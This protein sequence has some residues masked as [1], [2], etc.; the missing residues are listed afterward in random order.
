MHQNLKKSICWFLFLLSSSALAILSNAS[1]SPANETPLP[2]G[3]QVVL[4]KAAAHMAEKDYAEA[5]R[6]LNAFSARSIKSFDPKASDPRGYHH[7]EIYFALGNC[8]LLQN[9]FI[10][11]T[12]AYQKALA[13]D[14][15]HV[16]AWLNLAKVRYEQK[17][18]LEAAHCFEKGYVVAAEKNPEHLYYAACAYLMAEKYTRSID[19]FE[20]LGHSHP[21]AGKPAWKENH[22]HALLAAERPFDALPLIKLLAQT[23]T[24]KKKIQWQEIL[25]S[26]YLALDQTEK[27]LSFVTRLTRETP[28][29][30]KW[31]KAKAHVQLNLE[32]NEDALCALMIYGYL[33]PLNREEKKLLADLNLQMNIP[34]KAA[35]LYA[36]LTADKS[37]KTLVKHLAMAYRQQGQTAKALAQLEKFNQDASDPILLMLQGDLLYAMGKFNRAASAYRQA[38]EMEKSKGRAWLM[39]GYASWQA[40]DLDQ[41]RRAFL[42]AANDPSQEA[43]AREAL[44]QIR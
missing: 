1:T 6:T 39:A 43:A 24:G 18:P 12:T 13:R 8:Y 42:L 44:Q 3:V 31:W 15:A 4:Q 25:L 11:A 32:K 5:E 10:R 19:L 2:P 21:E 20:Q 28:T 16:G 26:Q 30:A 9:H 14:P 17:A 38:A 7:P 41:S 37:D 29:F 27:A 23:Y 22:V 36:E 40:R 34:V 35:P 33:T